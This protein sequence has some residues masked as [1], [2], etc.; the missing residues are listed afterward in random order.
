MRG[1]TLGLFA[2][3][4]AACAGEPST[5]TDSTQALSPALKHGRD[6]WFNE[7]FGG[8]K[9]FSL[10]VAGPP[11]NL[12]IGLD[13]ALTSP[14]AT[15]FNN[16]GLIN[17]PDCTPGDASTFG[18]DRC[19]DP[20]SAGVVGV[21]KKIAVVNGVPRILVGVSCASCHAGFDP[22]NPPADPN[23]PSW[24]NIHA[25]TG[26]QYINIAKIFSAHL[27]P[28]DP[29]YQVFNSWAP[30]TV[31]TTAIESDGINNPGIITQFFQVPDRPFFDLHDA[32]LPIHVHRGG[33][34]G[35][36]DVGCEKAALRVYFNIGMCAAECM[37]GHLHNGPGGSQTEIDDAECSAACPE[38]VRAKSEVAGMCAFMAT[39]R[40]PKLADAPGGDVAIDTSVLDRG[41][42]VF[43]SNCASCHSNGQPGGHNVL[44]N[45]L[46]APWPVV[47][48]NRCRSLSTNWKEGQI[49]G[50]FS[51]DEYKSR[52]GGG[53]G[54]YRNVPLLGIWATAPFFHNNR[55][56]GYNGDPSVAGRLAAYEDA[57]D[58]LL[59]PTHRNI[60]GSIIRAT[61]PVCIVPGGPTGCIFSLP[62][63]TPVNAFAS[64]GKCDTAALGDY[65]ENQGHYFGAALSASDKYALK[66][67]LKT[68]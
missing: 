40:T 54:F 6:V 25:T 22:V 28:S 67:Y 52:P 16:W 2:L 55:L 53:P 60:A 66:E 1:I 51:S 35:E 68:K 5:T 23:N 61:A 11:F 8:E 58:Q 45:D 47:G 48:T 37:V 38:Y 3:A 14:R 64:A 32:G 29:R 15:R 43:N 13:A 57:M 34:G 18:F 30:G 49:W 36:D 56:G 12:P 10:I 44:S 41:K 62:A 33:Q 17:D 65:F 20:E 59:N 63:G 24:D 42:Q 39:A 46:V 50:Q 19:A 26:N 4:T 9:F 27:T 31:D 7:T 21:R